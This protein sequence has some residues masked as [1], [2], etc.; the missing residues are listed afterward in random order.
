MG[1]GSLHPPR[2]DLPPLLPVERRGGLCPVLGSLLFNLPPQT[3]ADLTERHT[4]EAQGLGS[5]GTDC[6]VPT[7][8]RHTLAV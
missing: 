8:H 2:R 6:L 3:E 1:G 5:L 7:P 4:V